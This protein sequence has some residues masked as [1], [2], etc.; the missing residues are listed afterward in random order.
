M[1]KT[2]M[3]KTVK[4]TPGTASGTTQKSVTKTRS[5]IVA[6]PT[7]EQIRERAYQVYL[8]RNGQPGDSA[9]D[10]RQAEHELREELANK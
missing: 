10:W 2:T 8:R 1:A 9:S 4:S 7:E 5:K 6:L 3:K